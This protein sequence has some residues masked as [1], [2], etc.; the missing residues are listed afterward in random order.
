M[1]L[2]PSGRKQGQPDFLYSVQH[3]RLVHD[4]TLS[5]PWKPP[6]KARAAVVFCA[7]INLAH[8]VRTR[9][10]KIL[11]WGPQIFACHHHS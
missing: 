8:P 5:I 2:I 11:A 1:Y 6:R 9:I 10:Q 3:Y 7:E 4:M